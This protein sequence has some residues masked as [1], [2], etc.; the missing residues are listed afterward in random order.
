MLSVIQ[1]TNI[2]SQDSTSYRPD[3]ATL[4]NI[5]AYKD[6]CK[7]TTTVLMRALE[8]NDSISRCEIIGKDKEI[9]Y[10]NTILYSQRQTIFELTPLMSENKRLK[11]DIKMGW[12]AA[13][14]SVGTLILSI[15]FK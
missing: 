2:L 8:I 14:L 1:S 6:Y 13:I 12:G 5:L 4:A 3:S 11:R 9:E 10:L 15:I 7:E